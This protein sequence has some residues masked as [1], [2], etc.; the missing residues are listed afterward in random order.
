M[1]AIERKGYLREKLP[2]LLLR[3]PW[4][5]MSCLSLEASTERRKKEKK[6]R[7]CRPFRKSGLGTRAVLREKNIVSMPEHSLCRMLDACPAIP[8]KLPTPLSFIPSRCMY[9]SDGESHRDREED[10]APVEEQ[11]SASSRHIEFVTLAHG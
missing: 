6:R 9:S 8:E 3:Q 4:L 11:I 10:D 5:G 2:Q 7:Q 1:H